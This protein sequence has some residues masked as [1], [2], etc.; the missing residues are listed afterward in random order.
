[1]FEPIGETHGPSTQEEAVD[2]HRHVNTVGPDEYCTD[3]L[4]LRQ[5]IQYGMYLQYVVR[6]VVDQ[7]FSQPNSTVQS[8][9]YH[10]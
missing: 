2:E 1:M 6:Y 7:C 8:L 3:A 5:R 4:L 10:F 9:Y